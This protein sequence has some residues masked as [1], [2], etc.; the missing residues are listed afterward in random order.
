MRI[1]WFPMRVLICVSFTRRWHLG[2][3]MPDEVARS[4]YNCIPTAVYLRL[5]MEHD[6]T[7]PGC[8]M[9][10]GSTVV[11]LR[12]QRMSGIS[13]VCFCDGIQSLKVVTK[14]SFL[15]LGVQHVV[16]QNVTAV[17]QNM[18]LGVELY[19]PTQCF[20]LFWRRIFHGMCLLLTVVY[21][22]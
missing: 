8:A 17:F 1:F 16:L 3:V 19:A 14:R 6:E 20:L 12:Y 22:T 4:T 2:K 21:G 18:S 10:L 11:H 5:Y 13:V 15:S 9:Q 7:S